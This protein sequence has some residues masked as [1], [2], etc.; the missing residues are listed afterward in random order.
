MTRGRRREH[1]QWNMDIWGVEGVEAEAELLGAIVTFFKR[2][3]LKA[4]DVGIRVNS[5]GVLTEMLTSLGVPED[6]HTATCVLVDKLD[7]VCIFVGLG[8]GL[9]L[10]L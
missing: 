4:E 2:V 6:K 9:E 7:K 1:Y 3:G 10:G 8:L 5:R